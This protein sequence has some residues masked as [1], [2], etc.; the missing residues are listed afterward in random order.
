[1]KHAT[2]LIG[3]V[4]IALA[5][6]APGVG[7]KSEAEPRSAAAKAA[8]RKYDK[9]MEKAM[10]AYSREAEIAKKGAATELAVALKAATRAANLE[11]ANR[12]KAMIE[13][14]D[15]EVGLGNGSAPDVRAGKFPHGTWEVT[16]LNGNRHLYGFDGR[17]SVR[18]SLSGRVIHSGK[19]R[20]ED[21]DLIA[22]FDGDIIE[23]FSFAGD[24]LFVEHFRPANRYPDAS[25]SDIATG[26]PTKDEK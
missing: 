25:A 15:D 9:A 20:R 17:G 13:G 3:I 10:Q 7:A 12:I 6:G 8:I 1:M 24:R 18:C 19:L 5:A 11:E 26:L 4:M 16:Y 21:H 22:T 23:R 14:L 2:M